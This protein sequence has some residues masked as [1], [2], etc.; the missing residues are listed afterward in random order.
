MNIS[1]RHIAV[2]A[3]RNIAETVSVD[4]GALRPGL[5]YV[6]GANRHNPRLGPNGVGKSSLFAEA[7]TWCMHGVSATGLRSTEVRAWAGKAAPIVAL[8]LDRGDE[9][10][11]IKRGPR[12]SDVSIN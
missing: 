3:F 7:P 12:A 5:Y 8:T 1:L 9:R 11:V 2:S 10:V 6:R 4:L